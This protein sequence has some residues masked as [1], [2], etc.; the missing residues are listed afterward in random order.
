[1]ESV[2]TAVEPGAWAN[3]SRV[4]QCGCGL[5]TEQKRRSLV[6][7]GVIVY[8][9]GDYR[10]FA[11]NHKLK[12]SRS[13]AYERMQKFITRTDTCWLWTGAFNPHGYGIARNVG[14]S[15]LVHRISYEHNV[16]P[17]PEGL[18]LDH[19]CRVRACCNPAHL[20]PV[21]DLENKVRGLAARRAVTRGVVHSCEVV[22]VDDGWVWLCAPCGRCAEFPVSYKQAMKNGKHHVRRLNRRDVLTELDKHPQR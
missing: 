21:T 13:T 22:E 3:P 11:G 8:R 14:G 19:L 1:M 5:P 17:I 2:R 12:G 18:F 4:C 15:T 7:D 6:I 10:R 20:E 9:T 16:G